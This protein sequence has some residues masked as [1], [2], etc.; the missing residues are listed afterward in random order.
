MSTLV[1]LK[2][3]RELLHSI[4]ERYQNASWKERVK[5]IDG[6]IAA[7]GYDRKYALK[8]M[9]KKP[10]PP[11]AQQRNRYRQYDEEVQQVLATLWRAANQICSKRLHPF[12][13]ELLSA[14][15][16]CGHLS[17]PPEVKERLL[18][19]SPASIDRLL[20]AERAER[21]SGTS[22]TRSGSLLKRSIPI[23]TFADWNEARPGFFEADLV[24]HCG[25]RAEGSFLN[26]LVMT[27]ISSGWTEF[28]ALLRRSDHDVINALDCFR[29]EM[30][31]PLLGLDTDNGSEFINY[32]LLG[33]CRQ[34]EITFTRGRAYKKNDQ[35]HVE[36]KNGSIVRRLIG[37]DRFEGVE[38]WRDLT[39][40]YGALRLYVNFFQPSLK[41]MEKSRT[42]AKTQKKYDKAMTPYQRLSGSPHVPDQKKAELEKVYA[43]I[44]PVVLLREVELLQD[45][46]WQHA[47]QPKEKA[48][49]SVPLSSHRSDAAQMPACEPYTSEPSKHIPIPAEAPK[50]K[51]RKSGKPRKPHIWRTR[52]DPFEDDA[53][54]LH[55][56][57]KLNPHITAKELLRILQNKNP[58]KFKDNLL[59]TLQ[60][61]LREWRC[62][63]IAENRRSKL[64]I[65]SVI[66]LESTIVNSVKDVESN[67]IQKG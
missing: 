50:R 20:K 13:A 31:V 19:M 47:W 28:A 17:V 30:P 43:S 4:R 64:Q 27:D 7:T 56:I 48:F 45:R 49:D 21:K 14:L 18:R 42:G 34:N 32:Q 8:L 37:Y 59:R 51:Y 24:A 63:L 61:R 11:K 60:R 5:L 66:L 29:A 35:A 67:G 57:V 2:A 65:E 23:R 15:E 36:E 22:T 40:L 10:E 26:T 52:L 53:E 44:D 9:N 54:Q 16:R 55:L 33:Y 3:R 25:D 58:G 6:F 1:S 62:E 46:F 38:A 39:A 12:L 41:L